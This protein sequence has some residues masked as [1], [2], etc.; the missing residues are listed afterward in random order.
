MSARNRVFGTVRPYAAGFVGGVAAFV[1][2]YLV[3]FL[4]EG[5]DIGG[6][7]GGLD[8]IPISEIPLPADWQVIG[9]YFYQMHN[10]G[11]EVTVSFVG[12][13]ETYTLSSPVEPW[14]ALV[15]VAALLIAGFGVARTTNAE[16]LERGA[17]AGATVAVG[18]FVLV[19]AFALLVG[20]SVSRVGGSISVGP[21]PVPAALLAGVLYPVV[22]GAVGGAVAGA[23]ET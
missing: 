4:V 9:W 19:V 14:L 23:V 6:V 20:W 2:G 13:S 8:E 17:F 16:T 21:N 10:V 7:F 3:T 22:L 12:R 15:P 11:T 18:Y 1:A 5:R